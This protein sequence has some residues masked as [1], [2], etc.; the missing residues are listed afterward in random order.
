MYIFF[1]PDITHSF[2]TLSETESKHCIKSMRLKQGAAVHLTDGKG[3]LYEAHITDDNSRACTLEIT[4]KHYV[5]NTFPYHVHIAVAP[6]K[7]SDRYEWFVEK[8]VEI[9]ISE[10]TALICTNS[11]KPRIKTQ[12]IERILIAAL[13]QSLHCVLPVFHEETD[14]QHVV[15]NAKET[16]K[17]IAY[18]GD[19]ETPIPLLQHICKKN[20]DTLVLIG[21]E[22]DFSP[23][24]VQLAK[25]YDFIPVNLG[26]SRLRTETAA[27]VACTTI[28]YINR[29]L[30]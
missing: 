13:K 2:Y 28:H 30:S 25:Q 11:E 18:C 1:A 7:N 20:M 15:K 22:G 5:G 16:Q 24:E 21:P 17:F 14:F 6:T 3:N 29:E 4:D 10:I 9:G 26:K 8:A 27:L 23:Q 19:D 12:R